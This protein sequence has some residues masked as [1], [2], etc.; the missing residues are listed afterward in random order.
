VRQVP[1][2]DAT[3]FGIV[4]DGRVARHFHHYFNLLG[5]SV[6]AWS[7][8]VPAPP[9]PE[10][11][12]SCGTVLLLIRDD[13]IV[14]FVDTWPALREKQLVH[15]SGSL[16]T[17]VA[18][19]AHPLMTFGMELYDLAAYRSIPFVLD[20]GGS[21]FHELLPGLPNPSWT[22]P[23]TERP[24]YHALCVMAGNFS[25]LLWVKLLDELGARFGIP[26]S[27]AHPYIARVAANLMGDPRGALT[28][29]L[30]RGD[31]GTIAANLR[32]LEGDPFQAI[33][34]AFVRAYEQGR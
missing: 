3:P 16:V 31:T 14:T 32:A 26:A 11:L 23:A 33:Y 8:R 19:G 15:F 27:A 12:A 4:G 9:P 13:A 34:S 30:S 28:G 7:R 20:E 10:A 1:A 24:Y 2:L 5:L 18:E 22:I 6:R 25:A 21:P 17:A 29:P